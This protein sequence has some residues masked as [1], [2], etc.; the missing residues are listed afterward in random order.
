MLIKSAILSQASGSLAG[1]TFARNKGGMYVRARSIPTNPNSVGQQEV[2]GYMQQLAVIWA[3]TVTA[4]QREAWR[5]YAANVTMTNRLGDSVLLSA[6]QHFIRSNLPRLQAGLAVV[7]AGPTTY[8]LGEFTDPSFAIVG[9]TGVATVT[10]DDA[11]AWCDVDGAAMIFRLS[12]PV[13]PTINYFKGPFRYVGLIEGDSVTPPTSTDDL[14]AGQLGATGSKYFLSVTLSQ[15][16]GR[17]A[18]AS[19]LEAT[20][21]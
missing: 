12:R 14:P 9:A 19:I 13:S 1:S 2:R 20:A 5:V 3:S 7:A 6:Q 15:A 10:F 4:A 11:A 8:N 17:L 18:T 21:T 16:D